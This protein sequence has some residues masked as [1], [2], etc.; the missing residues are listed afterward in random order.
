MPMWNGI[1]VA[2]VGGGFGLASMQ[3]EP[4]VSPTTLYHP[5]STIL[6]IDDDVVPVNFLGSNL[7][8]A[9]GRRNALY[10]AMRR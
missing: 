3:W 7:T 1:F 8:N 4:N 9:H 5:D 10:H 2:S 6:T